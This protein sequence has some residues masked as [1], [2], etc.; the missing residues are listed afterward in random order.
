MADLVSQ[1]MLFPIRSELRDVLDRDK[2]NN[3]W[4]PFDPATVKAVDKTKQF[5]NADFVVNVRYKNAFAEP[6]LVMS[7]FTDLLLGFLR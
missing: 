7:D 1:V 6:E 5:P 3:R 4:I 2:D